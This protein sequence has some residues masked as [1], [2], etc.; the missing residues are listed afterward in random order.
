[1]NVFICSPV[2]PDHFDWSLYFP[3]QRNRVDI[4]DVG[5]GYGGLLIELS[6]E[7]PDQNILGIELRQKVTEY[8]KA[9]ITALREANPGEY[10]NI[11]VMRNNAMKFLPNFFRKGEISKMFFLFPDPHFKKKKHKARIVT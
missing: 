8:V 11:A 4:L 1:M 2:S 6:R 5:C 9:R 3:N 7:F 10:C